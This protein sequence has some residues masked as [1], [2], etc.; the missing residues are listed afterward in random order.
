MRRRL[1]GLP[2]RSER[3]IR[4]ELE[5]ELSFHLQART[6][7]LVAQGAAPEAAR[8]RALRE[9][10]DI[11]D[12]R[13][14]IRSLDRAAEMEKRRRDVMGELRQDLVYATRKLRSSPAFTLAAMVTL[15]L[16]IGANTAIFSV[17]DGVLFSPLPFPHPEQLV[18]VWS[19]VRTSDRMKTS[20]SSPDLDDWRAQRQRLA[21]LGGYWYADE[22]SGL[23]LTG[24]GEPRRL[25]V[26]FVTAGFF[27][28]LGVPAA[29][30]RLP[31]EEEMV[32][33]GPDHVVVLSYGFWQ[34]QFGSA[35][36][37][38]GSPVT[39]SG[40][41]YTVLGVM[42][43]D[44]RF[45]SERVDAWVTYSSIPDSGI[46]HIRP[47]RILTVVARM[48]PG[49][50]LEAARAEMNGIAKRL[51]AQYPEDAAYDGATVERL[52]DVITGPVRAGLLVLLGAVAFVL[53]LTCVNVAG[54]LLARATSRGREIATRLALGAARG[55]I[56]RQ[57]LTESLVLAL[58]GGVAGLGVAQLMV[59]GLL[60][61]SAGQLP[62]GQE[63]HLDGPV[64]LFAL[65]VTLATGI[66]F[67][68]APAI[69]GA[70]RG[71]QGT[72]REGGRGFAGGEG[73]RLRDALVVAEVAMAVVLVAGAG[74]MTRSF[75]E[76]L[77]VD[78]GF[79]P[80]HLLAAN[81]T[82]NTARHGDGY[83]LY[84]QQVL[85]KVRTV[86]GVLAA[87]AVKDAPFRGT[88]ER[89]GFRTPGMVVPAGEEGPSAT[90]L[91]VSDGYFSTIG[92]RI[93]SGREFTAQDRADAQH[94]V[95]VNEALAKRYYP[96]EDAAGRTILLDSDPIPIVGVVGD[97]RQS[98]MEEPGTPTIYV[99]NV[100]N[101]RVKVTLVVRTA[102]DPLVMAQT[103]REAIWSVDPDQTITS[104]FT[105]D[106]LVSEAVARPRLLTV[107]LAAFGI[108]GLALGALGIYGVLS[109]LVSRRQR[110]IGVRIAL[111]ARAG[112]VER[113]VVGRGL[114]LGGVGVALGLMGAFALTR[115]IQ[116]VLFG[117][118]ATDPAT[119]AGTVVVLLGAATLAS[120]LPAR[121]AAGVD[122]V[123][124]LRVD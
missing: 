24:Q 63:V 96:G 117:V 113:M 38:V 100:Q 26:A 8:T 18:Q 21:D 33:G 92:A 80:D 44:F 105:Y 40:E 13:R 94:V 108:L 54:L 62:R 48:R 6:E 77:H 28:T 118:A 72:L 98:A 55:R 41:D 99:D 120:W 58:A 59:R 78:P 75:V 106:D 23:D 107:L 51:A 15:A 9:F 57:L 56:V 45:P 109:Y 89:W 52:Q 103:L 2:W 64:L 111:G 81:F 123:A 27:N 30:G 124:A 39:L 110:E 49:V 95:L 4:E 10:G 29:E 46:P 122:P 91:H 14:Y 86:P 90:V 114:V 84:Y 112:E 121:R 36:S 93:V 25:S 115:Y 87:G 37:I 83:A 66:L 70:S 20:V 119:F 53:L 82:I 88:G 97:I 74:L 79:R 16:G 12:A 85:D 69:L 71:L 47:V 3:A 61:L 67:G 65:G 31:R 35:P 116:G 73:T 104:M 60:S 102:G 68:V 101:M 1:F 43:P 22:G 7:E 42:P 32:R 34:R 19:A 5:D 11:E 17:V 50:G 76:L